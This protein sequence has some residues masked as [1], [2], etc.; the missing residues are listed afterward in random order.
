M[1]ADG[2]PRSQAEPTPSAKHADQACGEA[3]AQVLWALSL[4]HL[5]QQHGSRRD[6]VAQLESVAA[7]PVEPPTGSVAAW[8]SL[9]L[10]IG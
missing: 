10:S 5:D 2:L 8:S 6:L 3:P 4:R 7:T 9:A 1:P